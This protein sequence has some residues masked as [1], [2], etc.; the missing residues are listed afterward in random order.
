MYSTPFNEPNMLSISNEIQTSATTNFNHSQVFYDSGIKN[1]PNPL[2][3]N[4]KR[5]LLDKR[6]NLILRGKGDCVH[7]VL[8]FFN[9]HNN[10]ETGISHY[11]IDT[12]AQWTYFCRRQ[13]QRAIDILI[14]N[15]FIIKTSRFQLRGHK[16]NHQLSNLYQL[17]YA[18]FDDVPIPDTPLCVEPFS[19]GDMQEV[20]LSITKKE[21]NNFNTKLL[22]KDVKKEKKAYNPT[23]EIDSDTYFP[24]R[25]A[26]DFLEKEVPMTGWDLFLPEVR[27]A[28]KNKEKE[29]GRK[30]KRYE[31]NYLLYPVV[32][33]TKRLREL[34]GTRYIPLATR[35]KYN[36][37]NGRSE[38]KRIARQLT[39]DVLKTFSKEEM[40]YY[41]TLN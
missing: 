29:I 22:T 40:D 35:I 3:Y 2:T 31:A 25:K 7:A 27:T 37:I 19:R 28:I 13:V 34:H 16:Y 41:N 14:V 26:Y 33:S 9:T 12:I 30:L 32:K 5:K 23:E 18:L 24:S 38:Y 1:T 15:N 6:A 17:N 4:D 39:E 36:D 20:T 21:L 11:A 10:F 8:R